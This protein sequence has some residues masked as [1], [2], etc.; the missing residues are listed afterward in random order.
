M[1]ESSFLRFVVQVK[2]ALSAPLPGKKAHELMMPETRKA[3]LMKSRDKR[4]RESAV[5]LLLYPHD[6][7][8]FFILIKREADGGVHSSQIALPGGAF[9]PEDVTL[10]RTALRECFEEVG[11]P[12]AGVT[13]IGRLSPL[14]IPPSNYRVNPF[15]GFLKKKPVL[16]PNGDEV[17]KVLEIPLNRLTDP[18]T[19][20]NRM[21]RHRTGKT[22]T[23][24]CFYL[25]NEVVWGATVMILNEFKM[26][27]PPLYRKENSQ[28]N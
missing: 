1:D 28:D 24:P 22:F 14:Y 15:V 2:E 17:E 10:E 5:L 12:P 16:R 7:T 8:P 21:I 26:L 19:I 11:V 3:E 25:D 23:V 20:Q 18:R 27:L 4:A 6:E 9:D 13:L